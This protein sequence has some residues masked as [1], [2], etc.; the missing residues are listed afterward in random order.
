MDAYE[1]K[2][3]EAVEAIWALRQKRLKPTKPKIKIHNSIY[4]S[5]SVLE[6]YKAESRARSKRGY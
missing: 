3:R 6:D 1:I 2:K 5:Q 4:Y